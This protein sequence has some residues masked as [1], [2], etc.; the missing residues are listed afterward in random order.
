ER[1][2]SPDARLAR[3]R[4]RLGQS[5]YAEAEADLTAALAGAQK[6]AALLGLSELLL[7]TGRY[8]DALARAKEAAGAGA[9]PEL[10]ALARARTLRASGEVTAALQ[11][12]Q[13]VKAPP[14]G[15]EVR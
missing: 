13:S 2:L 8:A 15:P 11:L 12:L 9:D 7:T 5:R 3:G 10:V 6:G 1:E 4:T 14:A